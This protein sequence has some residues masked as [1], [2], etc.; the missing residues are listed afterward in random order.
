[1]RAP[2]AHLSLLRV[3]FHGH[4]TDPPAT[5]GVR[6]M[7]RIMDGSYTSLQLINR[8]LQR[9]VHLQPS[10]LL[11]FPGRKCVLVSTQN[12]PNCSSI[13]THTTHT[14]HTR[15]CVPFSVPAYSRL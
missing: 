3:F 14:S 15:L 7:Q 4:F 12:S 13:S 10:D 5:E 1:M 2:F 11:Y 8:S 9:D 6:I